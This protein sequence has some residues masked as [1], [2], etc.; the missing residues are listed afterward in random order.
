MQSECELDPSEN[1]FRVRAEVVEERV[2]DD[3]CPPGIV[4]DCG[5]AE[6]EAGSYT[7]TFGANS[8]EIQVPGEVSPADLILEP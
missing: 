1:T 6:L 8:L 3:S 7:V 4:L 5:S 2:T